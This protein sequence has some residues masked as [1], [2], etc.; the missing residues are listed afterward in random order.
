M[1]HYHANTCVRFIPR[2]NQYNYV[3]IFAGEGCYSLV[4]VSN[5][6]QQPLSLGTG[7]TDHGTIVHELGHALGFYHEQNR[8]DQSIGHNLK[9]SN[10]TKIG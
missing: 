5:G 1:Q 6:G 7:C 2:T 9:S 3:K 10:L 4:G 8:S